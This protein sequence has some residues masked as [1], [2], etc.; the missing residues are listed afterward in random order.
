MTKEIKNYFDSLTSYAGSFSKCRFQKLYDPVQKYG[1][2]GLTKDNIGPAKQI[3][4]SR[5]GQYFRTVKTGYGF[6][7]LC[8]K[9]KN[10]TL[11][12]I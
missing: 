1:M 5:G 6:Y 10:D 8:F 3:L 12:E 2:Y 9:F 11:K 4:K 7:I